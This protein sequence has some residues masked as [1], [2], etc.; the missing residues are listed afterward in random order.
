MGR[1]EECEIGLVSGGQSER[2]CVQSDSWCFC[3][4]SCTRAAVI[5]KACVS[6]SFDILAVFCLSSLSSTR[7]LFFFL[8]YDYRFSSSFSFSTK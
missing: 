1:D 6:C 7:I 5:L 8:P 2:R 3:V 4:C